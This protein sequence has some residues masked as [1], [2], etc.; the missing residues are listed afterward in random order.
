MMLFF[1]LHHFPK[2]HGVV[3]ALLQADHTMGACSSTKLN[4]KVAERSVHSF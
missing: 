1:L 4:Q 3:I 2:L